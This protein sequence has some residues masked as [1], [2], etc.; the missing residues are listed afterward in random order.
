MRTNLQN[1]PQDGDQAMKKSKKRTGTTLIEALIAM[2][3]F[4]I[5][6][7]GSCKLLIAHRKIM[8]MARDHYTAANIAKNRYE[9]ARTFDFA[10]ISDLSESAIMV[11]GNGI[12]SDHGHFLRTTEISLLNT[13]AY[14]L[15]ITVNIQN[16]KTLAFDSAEQTISTFISK[17]P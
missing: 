9:M 7:T 1:K 4:S 12:A 6:T 13:N 15:T 16:R 14:E 3:I 2:A 8:D 10:Q 17:Q 5:F 11:D